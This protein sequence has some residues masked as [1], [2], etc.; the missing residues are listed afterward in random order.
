M[1]DYE[2]TTADE[3][4]FFKQTR[5]TGVTRIEFLKNY[6]EALCNRTIW[7]KIDKNKVIKELNKEIQLSN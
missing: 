3:I 1:I 6:K 2:W 7:D 4:R 5:P